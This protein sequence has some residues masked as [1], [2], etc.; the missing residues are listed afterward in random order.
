ME[1]TTQ[2]LKDLPI[3]GIGTIDIEGKDVHV[4]RI[5]GQDTRAVDLETGMVYQ[6]D[7]IRLK[8]IVPSGSSI[9]LIVK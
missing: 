6:G 2:T 7:T 3:S 9:T 1:N 8:Y 4:M 5:Y